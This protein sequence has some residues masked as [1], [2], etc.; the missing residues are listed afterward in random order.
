MK[1]K[2]LTLFLFLTAIFHQ[3]GFCQGEPAESLDQKVDRFVKEEKERLKIPG[4]SLIILKGDKIIKENHSGYANVELET[5]VNEH[6]A[7]SIASMSKTYTAAAILLLAER[8]KLD[9]DDGIRKYLP[10]A[11]QTWQNITLKQ[12]ISHTSGLVDDWTLDNDWEN[13]HKSLFATAVDNETFLERLYETPLQFTPGT[14]IKYGCGAFVLGVVIEKVSGKSYSR[15]MHEEMFEPLGLKETRVDDPN[16]II[17]HRVS[18]YLFENKKL[19]NGYKLS[20]ATLARADVS[21]RT[22]ARDI[23]KWVTALRGGKILDKNGLKLMYERDKLNDGAT[24]LSSLGW[25]MYYLRGSTTAE[26]TGGYRT[27]FSSVILHLIEDDL[28]IILLANLADFSPFDFAQSIAAIYNPDLRKIK[29]L[30]TAKKPKN[31]PTEKFEKVIKALAE[32]KFDGKVMSEKFPSAFYG[33]SLQKRLED[34]KS[35][36]Y[37]SHR[38]VSGKNM[39]VFDAPVKELWFYRLNGERTRY[40]VFYVSN[41]GKI[42]FLDYPE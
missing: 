2:I 11:P 20:A 7:F 27:G 17:P 8:G 26:H 34:V 23:A 22:S 25:L 9:L 35:I 31:A 10:E 30:P 4:L 39:R 42:V 29:D 41:D 33:K 6:S 32:E 13:T 16:E 15:F 40:T 19:Q 3:A 1:S 37:L 24:V 36:D 14:Q 18:G 28:T 21:I 12:L 5:P 38:N